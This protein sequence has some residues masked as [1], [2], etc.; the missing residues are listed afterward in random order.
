MSVSFPFRGCFR[1]RVSCYFADG[2]GFEP[3]LLRHTIPIGIGTDSVH[4]SR[5]LVN[6]VN[7]EQYVVGYLYGLVLRI[8]HASSFC[9]PSI[10][11][12]DY[13]GSS[14]PFL[15]IL[16]PRPDV[17]CLLNTWYFESYNAFGV[18]VSS[19]ILLSNS[20]LVVP[21]SQPYNLSPNNTYKPNK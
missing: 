16:S 4:P 5:R 1:F 9:S 19:Q 8:G 13:S 10:L 6:S 12:S 15:A 21:S 11:S 3:S 18:S 20:V 14:I 17:K 7:S 2:K